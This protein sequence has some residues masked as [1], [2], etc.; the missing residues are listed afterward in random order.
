MQLPVT[1]TMTWHDHNGV[2]Y[3][4]FP[5]LA[6]LTFAHHG[7]STR[8]GG[9]SEGVFTSMNLGFERGDNAASV[10]EN[11][12]RFLGALGGTTA[13][14]VLSIQTHGT[15][16][17]RVNAA[18]RGRGFTQDI[19]WDSVDGLITDI[20]G[21]WLCTRYADCVPLFFADPKRRA[22]GVSHAGWK[23]TAANIAG[24]T[25]ARMQEA[26]GSEATDLHVGIGPSIGACC[27]EVDA[28]VATA[29]ATWSSCIQDIGADK[30]HINLQEVNRQ[31]LLHAGV[32]PAHIEVTDLCTQ[33]H[34]E[35]FW[36]HRATGGIRGSLAGIIGISET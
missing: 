22:V 31:N 11:Y 8:L 9:V 33:C 18:D 28:P 6:S 17:E 32:L 10:T 30:Y 7:M 13:N 26:F 34:P 2:I 21:I 27:F 24:I 35:I 5:K 3:A 16:V 36:S 23:G 14:A 20:P 15:H 12:R 29:F 4:S 19:G 25:V 1:N